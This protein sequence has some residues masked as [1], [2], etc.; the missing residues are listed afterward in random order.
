MRRV[1]FSRAHSRVPFS[2]YISIYLSIYLSISLSLYI[3]ICIYIYII[4]FRLRAPDWPGDHRRDPSAGRGATVNYS[5]KAHIT[6]LVSGSISICLSVYLYLYL[7]C[8]LSIFYLY[9]VSIYRVNPNPN[10]HHKLRSCMCVVCCVREC[11]VCL[12]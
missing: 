7:D 12:C 6:V 2:G 3:Y 11:V 1:N 8:Y 4:G 9:Y 10:M 5:S